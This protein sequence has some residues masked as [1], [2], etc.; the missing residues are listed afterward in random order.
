MGLD[1]VNK[2]T[3]VWMSTLAILVILISHRRIVFQPCHFT[4]AFILIVFIDFRDTPINKHAVKM[5]WTF[6][7]HPFALLQ[8]QNESCG[9]WGR[10][11]S[12][13][14]CPPIGIHSVTHFDRCP[15]PSHT[16]SPIKSAQLDLDLVLIYGTI[17]QTPVWKGLLVIQLF[18]FCS[19]EMPMFA[20][21]QLFFPD[22]RYC[23]SVA[24]QC[25]HHILFLAPTPY[26]LLNPETPSHFVTCTNL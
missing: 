5:N 1:L 2:D 9:L 13:S 24:S 17:R 14:A 22:C 18:I 20:K 23:T 16:E 12:L 4:V 3:A 11:V 7:T 21:S 25:S 15:D 10:L 8:T 19:C 26:L 6:C